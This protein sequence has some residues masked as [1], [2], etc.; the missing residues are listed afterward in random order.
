MIVV[1]RQNGGFSIEGHAGYAPRGQDIV[2]AAVSALMQTLVASVEELTTD[3]LQVEIQAD[4]AVISYG[5]LSERSR[6]LVN[7]FFVGINMIA[8]T[9]P[10]HVRLSEHS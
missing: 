5:N 1:C 7:S 6:V 4:K 9:Y 2:C 10:D 8:E 3:I